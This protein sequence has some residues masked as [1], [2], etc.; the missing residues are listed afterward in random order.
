MKLSVITTDIIA[1][2]FGKNLFTKASLLRLMKSHNITGRSLRSIE[3]LPNILINKLS[4]YLTFL[5]TS[6][7]QKTGLQKKQ[8]D[9]KI[10]SVTNMINKI[11]KAVDE[12]EDKSASSVNVSFYNYTYADMFNKIKKLKDKKAFVNFD[13]VELEDGT[14]IRCFRRFNVGILTKYVVNLHLGLYKKGTNDYELLLETMF[15]SSSFKEMYGSVKSHIEYI[16]INS[17]AKIPNI[18][19]V[20]KYSPKTVISRDDV[21]QDKITNRYIKYDVNNDATSFSDFFIK[22][23]SDYLN[24]Y[25]RQY[26]CTYINIITT[27]KE[28]FDKVYKKETSKLTYELLFKLFNPD[29]KYEDATAEDFG[30]TPEQE[31]LFFKKYQLGYRVLDI[32]GKPIP[33]LCYMPD[34]FSGKITPKVM[35]VMKHN[36]HNYLLNH[37]TMQLNQCLPM[38][39]LCRL[40][41][42]DVDT[43]IDSVLTVMSKRRNDFSV[44]SKPEE[45]ATFIYSLDDIVKL[46]SIQDNNPGKVKLFYVYDLK[47]LLYQLLYDHKYEPSINTSGGMISSITIHVGEKEVSIRNPD[48]NDERISL[49]IDSDYHSI[50]SKLD[51]QY[52]SSFINKNTVSRYSESIMNAFHTYKRSNFSYAIRKVR[53]KKMINAIDY[54][55]AYPSNLLDIEYA[56]VFNSF[57]RFVKYDEHK[58]EDCNLYM[59]ESITTSE[60]DIVYFDSNYVMVFG[61]TLKF[62]PTNKY[63]IITYCRPYKLVKINTRSAL[64]DIYESSLLMEHKKFIPNKNIG[65]CKLRNVFSLTSI[66]QTEAEAVYFQ[67]GLPGSRI[68]SMFFD[69]SYKEEKYQSPLDE[70]GELV[71][72]NVRVR[73][74]RVIYNVVQEA[75]TDCIEGCYPIQYFVYDIMRLKLWQKQQELESLGNVVVGFNTDCIYYH[76]NYKTECLDKNSFEAIG[77]LK[78]ERDVEFMKPMHQ[79]K[80]NPVPIICPTDNPINHID[81]VDEYDISEIKSKLDATNHVYIR[82][83]VP[84]AGKS[85][86]VKNYI[87]SNNLLE[88]S[89]FVVPCNTLR[90]DIVRNDGLN[91]V[92]LAKLL[93]RRLEA[94]NM[95]ENKKKCDLK[96]IELICF[97]E[98]N[99]YSMYEL[100]LIV[101]LMKSN[102]KIKFVATGD[103]KQLKPIQTISEYIDYTKYS[104]NV[105]NG[106]FPNQI[107][108]K[109]CK[110]VKTEEHRQKIYNMAKDIDNVNISNIDFVKK[111]CNIIHKFS[112][113]PRRSKCLSYLNST[114]ERVSKYLHKRTMKPKETISV[115]EIQYYKG[116]ELICKESKI[117]S[118]ERR[119]YVNYTYQIE[120]IDEDSTI[121]IDRYSG[122]EYQYYIKTSDLHKVFRLPYCNTVH[123]FQGVTVNNPVTIFDLAFHRVSREWLWVATTRCTNPDDLYVYLPLDL[124]DNNSEFE[125]YLLNKVEGYKLQDQ[126]KDRTYDESQYIDVDWIKSALNKCDYKCSGHGCTEY[127]QCERNGNMTVDRIDSTLAHVKTNCKI[128][129]KRCNSAKSD[130]YV[131][132]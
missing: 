123:S 105:L 102:P 44:K 71:T 24:M 58:L 115:D 130:R 126:T 69:P 13:I 64:K 52:Y 73:D 77:K 22:S 63:N 32:H 103:H 31:L 82:A 91:C 127:I 42:P 70:E 80:S 47:I 33:E 59:I 36:E 40:N 111:Y 120:N 97:D 122:D 8:R 132:E 26:S 37:N 6:S 110:R 106:L 18:K 55:K 53:G 11:A 109:I 15:H 93:S 94:G 9:A 60:S 5:Q 83:C 117:F 62:M 85:T 88:K 119:L 28:S 4:E 1:K 65:S 84:G 95:I 34:T 56:P 7:A 35:N 90:L 14:A 2:V 79:I 41:R 3:D 125:Q 54:N 96:D 21:N 61:Y 46:E 121:I 108:L 12:N 39:G 101:E 30:T 49:I 10:V 50:Y 43:L 100:E 107:T 113:I 86:L 68:E 38:K 104:L 17:K 25:Y 74:A 75:K 81:I 118:K 124:E 72:R 67:E 27:F 57:D 66:F 129:C 23:N 16:G 112:Y 29:K 99:T 92:T 89:L 114:A 20:K 78:Y 131:P 87:K 128:M 48:Q 19:S 51:F 76:G 116:L 45:T 98:V